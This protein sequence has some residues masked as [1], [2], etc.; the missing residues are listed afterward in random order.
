MTARRLES[1]QLSWGVSRTPYSIP[2][3]ALAASEHPGPGPF[4]RRL[5]VRALATIVVLTPGLAPACGRDRAAARGALAP[6]ADSLRAAG[7][8][9]C[10]DVPAGVL[11]TTWQP[12][13]VC[14][15]SAA[16][17]TVVITTDSAGAVWVV[18]ELRELPPAESARESGRRAEA[19]T[20]RWGPAAAACAAPRAVG[21]VWRAAAHSVLVF[22]D[23]AR[24][25]LRVT[26]SREAPTLTCAPIAEPAG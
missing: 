8:F 16:G 17:A 26:H 23:T 14:E 10:T 5:W 4:H 13:R 24:G 6:L 21:G 3:Q 11:R 25:G 12:R 20:A 15:R 19:L 9:T 1:S 7:P 2:M 22:A 18:N